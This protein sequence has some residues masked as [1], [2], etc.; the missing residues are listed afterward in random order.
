MTEGQPAS[1]WKFLILGTAAM[2]AGGGLGFLLTG[3]GTGFA[4]GML[5]GLGLSW[6]ATGRV[7]MRVN[8]EI[9]LYDGLP[10]RLAGLLLTLLSGWLLLA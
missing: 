1:A 8:G 10:A 9:L 5:S 6:L 2:L 4:F 7:A 3:R